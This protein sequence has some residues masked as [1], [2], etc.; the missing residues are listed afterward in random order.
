VGRDAV[1][2]L[3]DVITGLPF[4]LKLRLLLAQVVLDRAFLAFD[5]VVEHRLA[6]GLG[7][8]GGDGLD[9]LPVL[10]AEIGISQPSARFRRR[11]RLSSLISLR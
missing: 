5:H 3:I 11:N 7:V 10:V 8:A 6:G 4:P 9:D 2:A 1:V